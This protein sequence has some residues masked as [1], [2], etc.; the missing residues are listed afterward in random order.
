M[1]MKILQAPLKKGQYFEEIAPKRNIVLHHTVSSTAKSALT[2][3]NIDP[4]RVATAF[5]VDKD[6]TIY[7]AFDPRM[8]AHHLG[9]KSIRNTELNKRSI[10]I[11]I[12][13]EGPL[14]KHAD[15]SYRWNFGPAKPGG[16]VYK[17]EVFHAAKPWKGFEYWAAYTEPQ[18]EAVQLLVQHLLTEF[19]MPPT[20]CTEEVMNLNIPDRYSIYSHYHVRADKTDV[21]PAWNY[22]RL[23]LTTEQNTPVSAF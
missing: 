23:G 18:Y 5:V 3:W 19:K 13:N 15:G 9:L 21:S 14:Y 20:L 22:S 17:G 10:G 8:W 1:Q 7:Q 6:G 11:E 16:N 2:W 4:Q 12:V